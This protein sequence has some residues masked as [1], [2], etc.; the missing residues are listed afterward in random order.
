MGTEEQENYLLWL[1]QMGYD[2]TRTEPELPVL[3]RKL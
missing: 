1:L 2:R 3:A